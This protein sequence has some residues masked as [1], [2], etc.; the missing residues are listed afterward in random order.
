M[1]QWKCYH[2]L[3]KKDYKISCKF[4]LYRWNVET[5]MQSSIYSLGLYFYIEKKHV[6][7]VENVVSN[8]GEIK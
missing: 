5:I 8:F 6:K 2:L 1:G 3:V 7:Q 4:Y